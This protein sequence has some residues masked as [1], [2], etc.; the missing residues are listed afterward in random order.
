MS[1]NNSKSIVDS[2]SVNSSFS[3]SD[4]EE[5]IKKILNNIVNGSLNSSVME[6]FGISLDSINVYY[7][8]FL[9][10]SLMYIGMEFVYSLDLV[11]A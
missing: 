9:I 6:K 7:I 8:M 2:L 4:V 5:L 1:R 11:L 10:M 3:K